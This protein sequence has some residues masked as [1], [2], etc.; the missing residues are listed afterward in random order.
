MLTGVRELDGEPA[1]SVAGAALSY[2]ELREAAAAV[3]LQLRG[4]ERVAVWA[5]PTLD[6]CVAAVAA[7]SAGIPLVPINPKLGRTEL[8]H[9]FSDSRPDVLVGAPDDAIPTLEQP[10]LR[11]AVDVSARGGE[12]PDPVS[13]DEDPALIIYTSGTTGRPKGAVLPRRA[14]ASNLDAL[15]DAW[16]WTGDD[17]VVHALPLFHV[18]GLVVGLFGPLR[19]GGALRHLGRFDAGE[20]AA[21]LRDGGTVMFGVP[22]MYHRLGQEAEGDPAIA[23]SLR[24]ARVLVSGSAALPAAEF[25]RIRRLTGQEI[26]ERYGMTETLM[27]LAVRVD[28]A[29]RPGCVGIPVPGVDVRLIDDDGEELDAC[30]GET[31]GEIIVRG[32]NLFTEYLKRPGATT[33]A[34]RDGWFHTGDIATR[35]PDGYW[36]IVGRR[37]TDLIK[38]G[39]YKVGAGE[40]EV[41]LLEHPSVQEV[42]VTGEPDPDL[43]ERII[44]W[45]VA[46]ADHATLERELIDHVAAELAP[47]KR[48]REVRFLAELPRNALGKVVKQQLVG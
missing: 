22:T 37:W 29:R 48:P 31:M 34:M 32:P 10:P 40:V 18:H 1:V 35:D 28:G 21:A 11:L 14:L 5:E 26:V 7:I 36:R 44:A 8:E 46:D 4:A 20:A 17:T 15:A 2:G 6:F 16:A 9:V 23:D 42:A 47:H 27:N 39:G 13:G 43:G 12:L 33:E 45:V 25:E 38:T 24:R 30:D 19:R 41:T 3:A